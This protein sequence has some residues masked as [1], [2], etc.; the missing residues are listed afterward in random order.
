MHPVYDPLT[1]ETVFKDLEAETEAAPSRS[2]GS[3]RRKTSPIR[4]AQPPTVRIQPPSVRI[5]PPPPVISGPVAGSTSEEINKMKSRH[6]LSVNTA[7]GSV[8]GRINYSGIKAD[9][10]VKTPTA[11]IMAEDFALSSSSLLV[12]NS[13]IAKALTKKFR[14]QGSSDPPS[15]SSARSEDSNNGGGAF[16][17]GGNDQSVKPAKK[18]RKNDSIADVN[19][20][21]DLLVGLKSNPGSEAAT[22]IS[23]RAATPIPIVGKGNV[24]VAVR[25]GFNPKEVAGVLAS[26]SRSSSPVNL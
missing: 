14:R 6:E 9:G 25:G 12:E 17:G 19:N 2:G 8:N 24:T 20:A 18:R 22:P 1:G 21:K 3:R 5:Q 16:F 10:F 11:D 26:L 13:M 23:S 15:P 4:T 7:L